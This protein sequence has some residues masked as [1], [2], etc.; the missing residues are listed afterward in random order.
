M[1]LERTFLNVK[2]HIDT[3]PHIVVTILAVI[4]EFDHLQS[5]KHV[6]QDANGFYQFEF[7]PLMNIVDDVE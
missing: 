4:Y 7:K 3:E 2:I 6:G 1:F 5:C